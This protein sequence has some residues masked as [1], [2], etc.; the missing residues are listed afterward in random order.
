MWIR[1]L[2]HQNEVGRAARPTLPRPPQK[3]PLFSHRIVQ[4]LLLAS[5]LQ[6]HL[7]RVPQTQRSET[8]NSCQGPTHG[9]LGRILHLDSGFIFLL[10]LLKS[11]LSTRVLGFIYSYHFLLSR[12]QHLLRPGSQALCCETDSGAH[13]P[14]PGRGSSM[15]KN[16]NGLPLPRAKGT[17]HLYASSCLIFPETHGLGDIAVF[18]TVRLPAGPRKDW[19][20]GGSR[21]Q[22]HPPKPFS[23]L[24]EAVW[25]KEASMG[26]SLQKSVSVYSLGYS[27]REILKVPEQKDSEFI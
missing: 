16:S 21:F 23:G 9:N 8:N 12:L 24:L 20:L 19:D 14:H 1:F 18:P 4:S 25:G 7:T 15:S 3:S 2:Q 6:A 5:P 27:F 22:S 17:E 13:G 11:S 10:I 26:L